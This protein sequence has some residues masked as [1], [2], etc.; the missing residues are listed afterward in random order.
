MKTPITV[1][2]ENGLLAKM[3]QAARD[4]NRT[5]TNFVETL[6]VQRLKSDPPSERASSR[7][8]NPRKGKTANVA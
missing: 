6:L 8:V 1:R 7:S 4:E 5:L 3:R 2:L